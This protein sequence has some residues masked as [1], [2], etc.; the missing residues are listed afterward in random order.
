MLNGFRRYLAQS[1]DIPGICYVDVVRND[2]GR[3]LEVISITGD[4]SL[5]EAVSKVVEKG[6][7]LSLANAHL[8]ESGIKLIP[9]SW[10]CKGIVIEPVGTINGYETLCRISVAAKDRFGNRLS[11][12]V[13][14]RYGPDARK[15]FWDE[16]NRVARET[17]HEEVHLESWN[18]DDKVKEAMLTATTK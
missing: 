12:S 11:V 2:V 15:K 1:K 3:Y 5:T 17:E 8:G 16:W 9:C 14:A 10:Q 4:L 18:Y 13:M 6:M 7:S